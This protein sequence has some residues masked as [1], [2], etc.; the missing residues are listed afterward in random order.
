MLANSSMFGKCLVAVL[1]SDFSRISLQVKM[2]LAVQVLVFEGHHG[3][4]H[5]SDRARPV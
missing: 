1:I 4:L 5:N 2:D 3:Q